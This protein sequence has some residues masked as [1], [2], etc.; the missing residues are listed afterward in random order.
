M[1]FTGKL[2]NVNSN[3]GSIK[4]ADVGG[5][6]GQTLQ[7]RAN[8]LAVETQTLQLRANILGIPEQS[9]QMR[10]NIKGNQT[11]EMMARILSGPQQTI[12]MGANILGTSSQ[13][14]DMR[15]FILGLEKTITMRACIV[16]AASL[17]MRAAILNVVEADLDV[18]FDALVPLDQRLMVA[19]Q[20]GDKEPAYRAIQMRANILQTVTADLTVRY[21]VDYDHMPTDC[22]GRPKT[23]VYVTEN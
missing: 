9:L 19:Y 2:G 6:A 8:I 18:T 1:P 5:A 13:S 17:Q 21:Q 14:L 3:L 4:L 7:L 15:A 16:H 10:A 11:L 20:I 23:R 22:I 12:D